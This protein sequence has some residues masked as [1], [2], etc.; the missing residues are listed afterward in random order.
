MQKN[1]DSGKSIGGWGEGERNLNGFVSGHSLGARHRLA[2][3]N[4]RVRIWG[5]ILRT[6]TTRSGG[7]QT[8]GMLRRALGLEVKW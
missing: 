1:I 7:C 6:F 5:L 8:E 3:Q 2:T 4:S